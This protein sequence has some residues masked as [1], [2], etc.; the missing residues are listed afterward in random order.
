MG[1]SDR[2]LFRDTSTAKVNSNFCFETIAAIVIFDLLQWKSW[3][4]VA[5]ELKKFAHY[6]V[7]YRTYSRSQYRFHVVLLLKIV[8]T[9]SFINEI[10]R[11]VVDWPRTKTDPTELI[12][13]SRSDSSTIVIKHLANR[14]DKSYSPLLLCINRKGDWCGDTHW[15]CYIDEERRLSRSMLSISEIDDVVCF[16]K[17]WGYFSFL[18]ETFCIRSFWSGLKS[19]EKKFA[20]I[21]PLTTSSLNRDLFSCFNTSAAYLT[22][23]LLLR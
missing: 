11:E 9:Q 18:S 10:N 23:G 4:T 3:D 19:S 1:S 8:S 16:K 17:Y 2:V 22:C 20:K 5:I 15:W 12:S 14:W 21:L 13:A 6:D 7:L